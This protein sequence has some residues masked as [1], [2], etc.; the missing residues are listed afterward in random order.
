ERQALFDPFHFLRVRAAPPKIDDIRTRIDAARL[1]EMNMC[2]DEPGDD[3]LPSRICDGNIVRNFDLIARS[4]VPNATVV[5]HDCCVANG[6][7][8]GPRDHR[9][10]LDD[11]YS[12]WLLLRRDDTNEKETN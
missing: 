3:P 8:A 12:T 4:D 7:T 1:R 10:A 11:T 9:R 5:D 6:R 2:I